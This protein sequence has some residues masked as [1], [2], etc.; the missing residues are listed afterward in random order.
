MMDRR[1]AILGALVAL[2]LLQPAAA[3]ADDFTFVV[4]VRLDNL[5]SDIVEGMVSCAVSQDR[6]SPWAGPEVGRES[7]TFTISGGRYRGEVTVVVKQLD[8]KRIS[9]SLPGRTG[10]SEEDREAAAYLRGQKR[11]RQALGSLGDVLDGLSL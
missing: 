9:L 10:E 8:G 11:G 7:A 6:D 5:H 1:V 2:T 3:R 4:P